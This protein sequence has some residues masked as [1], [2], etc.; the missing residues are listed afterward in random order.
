MKG[1]VFY[2]LDQVR[3]FVYTEPSW[4][5]CGER[6]E[7]SLP[8]SPNR[9][10]STS[11]RKTPVRFIDTYV[12]SLDLRQLGFRPAVLQ[13]TGRPPDHPGDLSKLWLFGYLDRVRSPGLD[14]HLCLPK[15]I[16]RCV[17]QVQA[18]QANPNGH[19]ARHKSA[20]RAGCPKGMEAR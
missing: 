19:R 20:D 13:E 9:S 3:T 2:M 8:S 4:T 14:R 1:P 18:G 5:I 17:P 6:I 15:D 12:G 7:I 16:G 11:P 10:T